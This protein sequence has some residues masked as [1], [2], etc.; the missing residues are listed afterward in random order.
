[1][2]MEKA[3]NKRVQ[4]TANPLRSLAATDPRRYNKKI[5]YK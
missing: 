4:L 5:D 2:K 1:M 3:H